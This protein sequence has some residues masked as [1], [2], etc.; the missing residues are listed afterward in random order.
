MSD[1]MPQQGEFCWN[2]LM[3]PDVNKA[4]QFYSALFDWKA[5]DRDMGSMTYT[6]FKSGDKDIGGML[7][8]PQDK[9]GIPPHWMSYVCVKDVDKMVEKAK[10]LGAKI[11]VPATP[12]SD[13]GR[14]A[15]IQDPTGA[16]IAIWQPTKQS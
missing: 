10:S 11:T 1:K 6:M 5:E 3:T 13:F 4:K 15:V 12:V 8:T 14:F 16:H 7:Q 2:E 9:A